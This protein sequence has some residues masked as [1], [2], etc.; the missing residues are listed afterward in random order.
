M[1]ISRFALGIRSL[2]LLALELHL[3][4]G[5]SHSGPFCE[6]ISKRIRTRSC[7]AAGLSYRAPAGC[8]LPAAS[9]GYSSQAQPQVSFPSAL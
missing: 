9:S 3:L 4:C 1:S 6:S 7:G 5:I 2:T 8:V